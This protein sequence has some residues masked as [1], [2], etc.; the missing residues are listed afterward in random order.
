MS[1]FA[2]KVRS[3]GFPRKQGQ[4]ETKREVSDGRVVS[5]TTEHW[6]GR[7]D[8]T[9]YP[10]VVRYGTKVHGTGKQKGEVAEVRTMDRKERRERYGD[11]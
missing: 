5:K 9:I 1:E 4:A 6:D 2:D 7:K 11:G 3:L 10:D 8:A